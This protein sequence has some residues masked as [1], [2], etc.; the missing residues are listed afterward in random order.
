M[1]KIFFDLDG[2]LLDAKD[3]LYL[4]FQ[5][6]V[7]TSTLS[8][9]EY[10]ELKKNR[11][12]H[13]HILKAKFSYS[14]EDVTSFEK[15]WLEKIELD[16]WL[17]LDRPFP[18]VKEHLAELKE[19]HLLYV[20]TARQSKDRALKQLTK[21]RLI[22]L[23]E[24]VFVTQHKQDKYDLI[25]AAVQTSYSDWLVGDTG[26]DIQTGKKLGIKTVAVLS[27][28]MNKEK[29]LEYNPDLIID[30]VLFFI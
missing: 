16:E 1:T 30:N 20:V 2:T 3:R 14:D 25:K 11:Y 10:W 12:T 6:L 18:G 15:N 21:H 5:H 28:F 27:G 26:N 9:E 29:L 8:F 4:L 13:R 19:N 17:D 22:N 23:F 24:E 7:P